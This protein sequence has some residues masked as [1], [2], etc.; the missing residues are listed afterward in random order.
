MKKIMSKLP[1][2]KSN[3]LLNVVILLVLCNSPLA[4]GDEKTSIFDTIPKPS[5]WDEV[6]PDAKPFSNRQEIEEQI[7][8]EIRQAIQDKTRIND[9]RLFYKRALLTVDRLPDNDELIPE[10]L[11]Y[12]PFRNGLTTEESIAI[13]EYFLKKYLM[14]KGK[15]YGQCV[16]CNEGAG[17]VADMVARL[18]RGYCWSK[19]GQ[20]ALELIDSFFLNRGKEVTIT[21]K[22]EIYEALTC[23]T[24][25]ETIRESVVK[26]LE[27]AY[28]ELY[29]LA[30]PYNGKESVYQIGQTLA[31]Y[32]DSPCASVLLESQHNKEMNHE[33][34]NTQW[35][36]ESFDNQEWRKHFWGVKDLVLYES[37][38]AISL[39]KSI[40][41]D[42]FYNDKFPEWENDCAFSEVIYNMSCIRNTNY[43]QTLITY[44]FGN[45]SYDKEK[46]IHIVLEKLYPEQV[47]CKRTIEIKPFKNSQMIEAKV[48]HYRYP[49]EG[50]GTT[51]IFEEIDFRG[52]KYWLPIG[53]TGIWGS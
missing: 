8:Q 14:W 9:G 12:V 7:R 10:T 50:C 27:N 35:L 46:Q 17:M 29:P 45:K 43:L 18:V 42:G 32:K 21:P 6:A 36:K 30:T 38:E 53:S 37:D 11:Y 34:F 15:V 22:A 49:M 24:Q 23:C 48:G 20:L 52:E 26:R 5:W 3:R 40:F 39:T 31:G 1:K 4:F 25:D 51:I 16:G 41:I 2:R 47:G 13:A 44:F 19:K 28:E 33:Q